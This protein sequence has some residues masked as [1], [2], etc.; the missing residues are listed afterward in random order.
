MLRVVCETSRFGGLAEEKELTARRLNILTPE[1]CGDFRDNNS[2]N[3]ER[4]SMVSTAFDAYHLRAD[5]GGDQ[6]ALLELLK[7]VKDNRWRQYLG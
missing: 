6:G 4:H 3:L 2:W 5:A 1:L 7:E